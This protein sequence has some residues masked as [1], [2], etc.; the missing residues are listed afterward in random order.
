MRILHIEDDDI[1]VNIFTTVFEHLGHSVKHVSS[2]EAAEEELSKTTYDKVICDGNLNSIDRGD[3]FRLANRLYLEGKEVVIFSSQTK[4][5]P[6]RVPFVKKTGKVSPT[7]LA[8]KLL[9]SH[10]HLPDHTRVVTTQANESM[11]REWEKSAWESRRWG[12]E[13]TIIAHHDSHG[14]HYDIRHENGHVAPY[15]P[16]EVEVMIPSSRIHSNT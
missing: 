12:V 14:L 16:S 10:T 1:I 3:G 4:P 6:P 15:D 9:L 5:L 2:V 13:G 11:Q 7:V 8:Q